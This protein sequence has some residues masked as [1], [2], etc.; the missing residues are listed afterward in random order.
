MNLVIISFYLLLPAYFANITASLAGRLKFLP[1]PLDFNKKLGNNFI[2]GAGKTLGGSLS[3]IIIAILT[4]GLQK[5][6]FLNE[7]FQNI[8]FINYQQ[9]N[10]LYLGILGGCGSVGGDIIASFFKRRLGLKSGD[11]APLLDQ[12]DYI[13]F[14]FLLISITVNL[15]WEIIIA[16]LIL[17]LILHP[18]ANI[19]S[20]LLKIKK[21]WW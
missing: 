11:M 6:L 13:I 12:L 18:L 3:G 5:L 16:S 17:T 20:Y 14:Y 8:S 9:I 15:T 2:L 7:F 21:V 10:W 1:Q 4:A 19:L